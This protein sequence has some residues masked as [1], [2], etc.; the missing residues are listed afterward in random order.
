M[1]FYLLQVN[2][3]S[4]KEQCLVTRGHVEALEQ[5]LIKAEEK[6][7]QL[8]AASERQK[9]E[10]DNIRIERDTAQR[11]LDNLKNEKNSLEQQRRTLASELE[12]TLKL[13]GNL[14]TSLQKVYGNI[15]CK[16]FISL[17]VH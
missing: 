7:S 6:I 8:T 16:Y 2:L 9:D 11:T 1:L 5:D 3:A 12:G 4:S 15:E 10:L 14:A 17:T 13:K